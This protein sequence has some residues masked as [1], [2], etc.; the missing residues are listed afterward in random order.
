MLACVTLVVP[1]HDAANAYYIQM[2]D[3]D[4]I[5]DTPL[6]KDQRW[7]LVAPPGCARR[8]FC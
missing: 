3:F 6:P 2:L 7:V 8:V 5:E 1:T 4:L